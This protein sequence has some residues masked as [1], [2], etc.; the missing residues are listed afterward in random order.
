[1]RIDLQASRIVMAG[2]KLL[3]QLGANVTAQNR[4]NHVTDFLRTVAHGRDDLVFLPGK[5]AYRPCRKADARLRQFADMLPAARPACDASDR[6]AA[7]RQC[8]PQNRD[9]CGSRESEPLGS[10][11]HRPPQL[12]GGS[13]PGRSHRSIR[14]GRRRQLG[15][16]RVVFQV[17][18]SLGLPR[19][20]ATGG[21]SF[22]PAIE[23][24]S[25]PPDRLTGSLSPPGLHSASGASALRS[26]PARDPASTRAKGCRCPASSRAAARCRD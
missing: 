11:C 18:A 2:A 7:G 20:S 3:A 16:R 23:V 25:L 9:S 24:G 6:A 12:C 4:I 5:R 26:Y 17:A 1:V 15:H 8:H 10:S 14:P 22:Q 21:G 19:S 13:A